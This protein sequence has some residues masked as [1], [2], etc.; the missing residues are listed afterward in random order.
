MYRT[1]LVRQVARKTGLSQRHVAAVLRAGQE[2]IQQALAGG[3]TVTLT[4]LGTFYTRQQP[5]GTVRHIQTGKSTRIPAH[6]VAAFRVGA[7][8]RRAVRG[9]HRRRR[10]RWL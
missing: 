2:A 10:H 1:D 9:Q 4:G 8:L 5:A 3:E 6:R 7:V